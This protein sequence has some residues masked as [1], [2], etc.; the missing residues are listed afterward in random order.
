MNNTTRTM[1]ANALMVFTKSTASTALI[2]TILLSCNDK[3]TNHKSGLALEGTWQLLSG[4][5]I[6]KGDTVI[7]DYTKEQSMIKVI[8][9]SHFAFLNHDLQQG[10]DKAIFGAGGGHYELKGDQYTEFL[11]YCSD[12]QWEGNKFVFT[13]RIAGDTLTQTGMEKIEATGVDRMNIEKYVR[14]KE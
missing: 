7:T 4:T 2:L 11:S 6:E 8:N 9:K 5:T 10:K 3:H 1:L 12:R 14:L 13:V